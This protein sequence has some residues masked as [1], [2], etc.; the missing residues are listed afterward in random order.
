MIS[1]FQYVVTAIAFSVSKPFRKPIY[2]N[3]P[4]LFSILAILT[5][6][7]CFVFLPNPNTN[8]QNTD[9][10]NWLDNFFL[11]EP[12]YKDGVSYY[13]YRYYIAIG[14]VINSVTTLL[15]EKWFIVRLT[16]MF[17]E[18]QKLEKDKAFE[19]KMMP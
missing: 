13:S 7:C 11:I 17:D 10:G 4:F 6:N 1:I 2:S 8:E 5:I 9:G 15:W 12:F 18:K 14:I 3:I 16:A 19:A